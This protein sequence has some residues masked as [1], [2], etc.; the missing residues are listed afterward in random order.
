ML[1][2]PEVFELGLLL[3]CV[4]R[5]PAS[6]HLLWISEISKTIDLRSTGQPVSPCSSFS[7]ELPCSAYLSSGFVYKVVWETPNSSKISYENCWLE[8]QPCTGAFAQHEPGLG[9]NTFPQ[10]IWH[11]LYNTL[12]TTFNLVSA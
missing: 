1:L 7:P 8:M 4:H 12:Q 11:V 10:R 9:F 3:L 5:T 6:R 2:S